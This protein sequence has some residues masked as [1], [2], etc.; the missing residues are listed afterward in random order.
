MKIKGFINYDWFKRFFGH[1]R[2]S[3]KSK[4]VESDRFSELD[5][6]EAEIEKIWPIKPYPI[7][8]TK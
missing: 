1:G 4:S 7:K 2:N 3:A 5:A 8:R 6:I